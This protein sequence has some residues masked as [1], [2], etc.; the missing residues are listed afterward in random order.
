MHFK[1]RSSEIC[2]RCPGGNETKTKSALREA[3]TLYNLPHICPEISSRYTSNQ[4]RLK[5]S[6]TLPVNSFLFGGCVWSARVLSR[7]H[8]AED[9]ERTDFRCSAPSDGR[10]W[11]WMVTNRLR[12]LIWLIL[13]HRRVPSWDAIFLLSYRQLVTSLSHDQLTDQWC[14][15]M[16]SSARVI[17]LACSSMLVRSHCWC[18]IKIAVKW[19]ATNE[20]S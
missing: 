5:I 20:R 2:R 6:G 9:E 19:T 7:L 8:S 10:W 3:K 15:I 13:F 18:H 16:I 17:V 12:N 1:R 14:V 4:H 11:T